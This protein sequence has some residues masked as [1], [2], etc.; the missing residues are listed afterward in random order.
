MS[1]RFLRD[2]KLCD[3]VRYDLYQI[4]I[5]V[6]DAVEDILTQL[7][8]GTYYDDEYEMQEDL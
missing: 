8:D 6:T 7:H 4:L 5:E 2:V 1:K 3:K